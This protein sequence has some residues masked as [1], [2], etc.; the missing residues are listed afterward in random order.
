MLVV[1]FA[2]VAF[3]DEPQSL[4]DAMKCS[5]AAEWYEAAAAEMNSHERHGTWSLVKA[6]KINLVNGR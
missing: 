4:K 6:P 1:K 3:Q 5:D 2:G